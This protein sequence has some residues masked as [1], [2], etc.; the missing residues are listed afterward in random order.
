MPHQLA[1]LDEVVD[2]WLL[3]STNQVPVATFT[4]Q[5]ATMG[6]AILDLMSNDQITHLETA[7]ANAAAARNVHHSRDTTGIILAG[8]AATHHSQVAHRVCNLPRL[9]VYPDRWD[10]E[11]SQF[12]NVVLRDRL[13]EMAFQLLDGYIS[14]EH[15]YRTIVR[16]PS[17][18]GKVR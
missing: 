8:R 9:G 15:S 18:T 1:Q 5:S 16:G 3:D 13:V 17:G 4:H 10:K 12:H 14:R 11:D 6:T 7:V 2:K